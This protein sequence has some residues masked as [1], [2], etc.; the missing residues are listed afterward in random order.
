MARGGLIGVFIWIDEW[1]ENFQCWMRSAGEVR[2]RNVPIQNGLPCLHFIASWQQWDTIVGTPWGQ[3]VQDTSNSPLR[4]IDKSVKRD[5]ILKDTHQSG[6]FAVKCSSCESIATV[7][8][9]TKK[10]ILSALSRS[11]LAAHSSTTIGLPA[12]P[13]QMSHST[14]AET[15]AAGKMTNSLPESFPDK[16][17]TLAYS[18]TARAA[19]SF[20]CTI[21]GSV[22]DV[23]SGIHR[24]PRQ[25]RERRRRGKTSLLA[26]C[27]GSRECCYGSREW[28]SRAI[29][30]TM[31]EEEVSRAPDIWFLKRDDPAQ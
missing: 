13:A 8:S 11:S 16:F 21:R 18:T 22:Y 15:I 25:L 9:L 26:S 3:E 30:V 14:V 19:S 31:N 20:T 24:K 4:D 12:C 17:M 29:G 10:R 5:A 23:H 1:E 6:A 28:R 2:E 27:Y 7:I